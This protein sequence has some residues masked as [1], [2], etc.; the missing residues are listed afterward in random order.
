M[1]GLKEKALDF[2][3]EKP[4]NSVRLLTGLKHREF[5]VKTRSSTY[6]TKQRSFNMP[7]VQLTNQVKHK[8]IKIRTQSGDSFGQPKHIPGNSDDEFRKQTIPFWSQ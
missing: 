3:D 5:W 4:T 6:P 7:D 2:K 1:P 8:I